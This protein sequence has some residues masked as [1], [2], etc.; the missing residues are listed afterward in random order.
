M[1]GLALRITNDPTLAQDV[2]QEAF[3]GVWRNASRFEEH[4]DHDFHARVRAGYLAMAAADPARWRILDGTRSEA[5]VAGAV[6]DE[7][8]RLLSRDEPFAAPLRTTT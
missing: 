2:V 8:E 7:V 5:D 1:Y 4:F 6:V 3:L